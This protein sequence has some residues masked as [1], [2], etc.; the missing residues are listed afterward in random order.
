[1]NTT[2]ERRPFIDVEAVRRGVSLLGL[3]PSDAKPRRMG[4]DSYQVC[5]CTFHGDD[6]PS[7]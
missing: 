4:K 5:R 7:T 3:L 2:R 1:M 6:R